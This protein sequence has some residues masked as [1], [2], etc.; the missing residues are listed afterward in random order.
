MQISVYLMT[1]IKDQD[2]SPLVTCTDTV[3]FHC[4]LLHSVLVLCIK[5]L[6]ILWYFVLKTL[7][8]GIYQ[9][10]LNELNNTKKD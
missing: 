1:I 10:K 6:C 7:T 8:H 9:M 4:I 3:L 2:L 5:F